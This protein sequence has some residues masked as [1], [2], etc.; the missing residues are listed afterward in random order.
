MFHRIIKA[1]YQPNNQSQRFYKKFNKSPKNLMYINIDIKV[2]LFKNQ[3]PNC[4][5]IIFSKRA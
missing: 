2:Q 4:P 1:I 3:K 5:E